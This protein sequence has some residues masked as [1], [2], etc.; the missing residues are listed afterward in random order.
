MVLAIRQLDDQQKAH[1]AFTVS[2]PS[3]TLFGTVRIERR[4]NSVLPFGQP[5]KTY[6]ALSTAHMY[7]SS[8]LLLCVWGK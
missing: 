5:K 3:L 8:G 2:I 1:E 4:T 6:L 7:F